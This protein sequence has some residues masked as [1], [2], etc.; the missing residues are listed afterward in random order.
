M[1][2]FQALITENEM[3]RGSNIFFTSTA[4]GKTWLEYILTIVMVNLCCVFC[5]FIILLCTDIFCDSSGVS[6]ILN[7][8]TSW[9]TPNAVTKYFVCPSERYVATYSWLK[10]VVES[11]WFF[12]LVQCS[13]MKTSARKSEWN[14]QFSTSFH[15]VGS[16]LNCFEVRYMW[17]TNSISSPTILTKL[18]I[19]Y[20]LILEQITS[21]FG[22]PQKFCTW[23]SSFLA[24]GS[25]SDVV[26][27]QLSDLN[28][29]IHVFPKGWC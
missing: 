22:L 11:N 29:T 25:I 7:R 23:V 27:G 24:N 5:S 17:S 1:A 20:I 2:I 3:A 10:E 28:P 4:V 19:R 18:A 12:N 14:P 16:C 15:K 6:M 9:K 26:D 8:D 13:A 21:I